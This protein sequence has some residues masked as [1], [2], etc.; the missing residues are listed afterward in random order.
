MT[1]LDPVQDFDLYEEQ[2]EQ[3]RTRAVLLPP[4][5]YHDWRPLMT[6]ENLAKPEWERQYECLGL[7][8]R[9]LDGHSCGRLAVGNE[10][11]RDAD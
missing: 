10:R 9:H 6:P 3:R 7:R 4:P 11:W 8:A 1:N 5:H 2:L